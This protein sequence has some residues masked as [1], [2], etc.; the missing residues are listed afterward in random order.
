MVALADDL[1]FTATTELAN[2]ILVRKTIA[3]KA[4]RRTAEKALEVAGGFGFHRASGI[5]R[6]VRD[7]HGA[8]FHPLPE[9]QQLSFT[10]RLALG[11]DP[12]EFSAQAP[13]KDKEAA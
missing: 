13:E 5:E 12:I 3:A 1:R 8:L 11:L 10:G 6:L 9:K 7:S 2:E 4:V